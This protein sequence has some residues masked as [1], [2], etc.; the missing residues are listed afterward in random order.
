[1]PMLK[2]ASVGTTNVTGVKAYLLKEQ[3]QE[4]EMHRQE[5]ERY[6]SGEILLSEQQAGRLRDYLGAAS[7]GLAVDVSDDLSTR[8]W[9]RQ[10]DLTRAQF[11]HDR[12]VAQGGCRTYYHFILSPSM[13]DDCDLGTIRAYSKAWA[14]ANFRSGNRKHEYAI[15]YHDDN[16]KGVLHAHLVV[17]VTNKDTGRKL[18]LDNDE[19]VALQISA[20]EIGKRYGLTPLRE[21]MQKTIGA[22]TS[23]PIYLDR[24]EREILSKGGYSWKWEL[25]KAIVDISPLAADFDD[26]KLKLNRAGYDVTRSPKTGYL[27]YTHK[28]GLKVKDSNLGA[29]F[30]F[31]SLQMVFNHESLLED[32]NY[33]SW[34]LLKISKG[35]IPWKE[36]IRRAIDEIVPTVISIP[37][38]QQR[39]MHQYGI[40]LIVNRRGLTYQ[41]PSGYKTRDISIGQRYTSEG[42]RHNAVLG[43]VVPYPGYNAILNQS[44]FLM[45]HYLPRSARGIGSDMHEDA[46]TRLVY[47]DL[48]RLMVRNG[49]VRI[50]DVSSM[51]EKRFDTLK[52]DKAELVELRS[53]VMRWNHLAVLQSRYERDKQFLQSAGEDVDPSLYNDTL[54]RFERLGRYLQEQ[55]GGQDI[56]GCHKAL[57]EA[58]EGRLRRYQEHLSALNND[59]SIYQNY[60]L[61]QTVWK[62]PEDLGLSE[63][64]EIVE[65]ESLF[66]AGRTLS[67]HHI[68]D[69]YHLEQVISKG[70]TNLE[71]AEYRL[72]K[73]EK[74]KEELALIQSDIRSCREAKAY[75]PLSEALADRPSALGIET[76]QV[77]F[78]V[79]FERLASLGI[80]EADFD[81]QGRL[82]AQAEREWSEL[83]KGRDSI[84]ADVMEL[85]EARRVCLGIAD[86]VKSPLARESSEGKKGGSSSFGGAAE[87]HNIQGRKLRDTPSEAISTNLGELPIE[88]AR[89]RRQERLRN[90][91]GRSVVRREDLLR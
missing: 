36:D 88:E 71:L 27:T 59:Q 16:T 43:M 77:R 87:P 21:Q 38:L 40:R 58:L 85:K 54:I 4:H 17:N 82:F 5:W 45:R 20:Q 42:L 31:E 60:L 80:S 81:E 57:N 73:A 29:R 19:V 62:A 15:V 65:P 1:M 69:F 68:R 30:Y 24:R 8:N 14:E 89:R 78:K 76:Q 18:H 7:R 6:S 25:R 75:I 46:A 26:F 3:R 61:A 55:A 70:E 91:P 72:K 35:E 67:A 83:L 37:E 63:S 50:E 22:R 23:Q 90:A 52:A 32:R 41:H 10:M 34:E 28:N 12:P 86:S 56:K 64:T 74:R 47:R 66:A 79:A 48:S 2:T 33:A 13:D 49:L 11:R 9:A 51:L 84:R 39:L 53:Q 44:S